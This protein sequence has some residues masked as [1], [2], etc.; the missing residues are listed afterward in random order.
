MSTAEGFEE[1]VMIVDSGSLTAAARTLGLPRPT[2]SRRLARL[3]ERLG[4]RLIYR[5]TRRMK[6][7][8]QGVLLY[9]KAHRVVQ[10][11]REVEAEVRRLDGVPRGL[12]RVSIPVG[13]SG[14]V[15]AR[16]F[17]T[18]MHLWPE[19]RLDVVASSVHV[20]LIG[21][22]FDVALRVGDVT[23]PAL[24]VRTIAN[25]LRVAVAS[26]RYLAEN[27]TPQRV[28]D[29]TAHNCLIGYQSGSTPETRWP[30]QGGGW[31]PVSG[32]FSTNQMGMRMELAR[33]HLGIALLI[34]QVAA[35]GLASGEL[36]VVLPGILGHRERLSLTYPDRTFLDP[37]VRV[38]VDFM[39]TTIQESRARQGG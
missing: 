19:V 22:G 21:D 28:E 10:I 13:G 39:A 33:E 29:L 26:P 37:K 31:V 20:D 24:V 25:D 32:T 7:T 34:D 15:F 16:W 36:V 4:V 3:E 11:A 5:T 9:E 27:G 35:S 1:F 12:L 18:F 14:A 8:E 6:L 23:D 30:L 38:F 2:L 17:S